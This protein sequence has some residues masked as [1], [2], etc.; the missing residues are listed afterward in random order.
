MAN[1]PD[2]ELLSAYLDGELTAE[3]RGRVERLLADDPAARQLLDELR[4]VSQTIGRLPRQTL[5]EDLGQ[6]VLQAAERRILTGADERPTPRVEP[7][8]SIWREWDWR[9]L[10]SRRALLWSGLAVAVAIMLTIHDRRERAARDLA[11][12]PQNAVHAPAAP[13]A[14]EVA[15]A[16]TEKRAAD[17]PIPSMRAADSKSEFAKKE[18]PSRE[19]VADNDAPKDIGRKLDRNEL[20]FASPA[21]PP[22][23]TRPKDLGVGGKG[24]IAAPGAV[25][26]KASLVAEAETEDVDSLSVRRKGGVHDEAIRPRKGPGP[27]EVAA[28]LPASKSDEPYFDATGKQLPAVAK[29]PKSG[30]LSFQST[31]TYTGEGQSQLNGSVTGMGGFGYLEKKVAGVTPSKAAGVQPR[32]AYV[33]DIVVRCDVTAAAADAGVFEKL[34]MHDRL[35]A[36]SQLRQFQEGDQAE[37]QE[38]SAR[39]SLTQ[40]ASSGLSSIAKKSKATASKPAAA[41]SKPQ[42]VLTYRVNATPAQLNKLLAR[43]AEHPKDFF[44][45]TIERGQ[46]VRDAFSGEA[47]SSQ[48]PANSAF[49]ISGG[50]VAGPNS[51]SAKS[52]QSNS[53]APAESVASQPVVRPPVA[54]QQNAPQ[55]QLSQSRLPP[56]STPLF[57]QTD[58]GRR[59]DGSRR[60]VFVLRVVDTSTQSAVETPSQAE[61]NAANSQERQPAERQASPAKP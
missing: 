8:P 55:G 6:R 3:E 36:A 54:Q 40:K 21:T 61:P 46:G 7:E 53:P 18:R 45:V 37:I 59:S 25:E 20:G 42:P 41:S 60:V 33:G 10:F 14:A 28:G 50:S 27:D 1:V 58:G 30:A 12:A 4:A 11:M 47:T 48:S 5:D 22:P 26:D 23:A 38:S 13:A 16:A 34:L 39:S 17:R 49:S 2:Y 35:N 15:D 51:T 9:G 56:S 29:S 57:S 31:Q 52:S 24:G 19:A 44:A 32:D 43:L